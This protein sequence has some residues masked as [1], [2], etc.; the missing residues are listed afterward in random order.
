MIFL[1]IYSILALCIRLAWDRSSQI[2]RRPCSITLL[3]LCP[4]RHL[5]KWHLDIATGQASVLLPIAN[6]HFPTTERLP[7][8][9]RRVSPFRGAPLFSEFA[10]WTSWKILAHTTV[11]W[12]MTLFSTTSS[13]RIKAMCKLKLASDSFT[14]KA[15]GASS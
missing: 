15:D 7:P 8:R 1:F 14:S 12:T 9:W 11:F 4:I 5:P 3:P 2:K 13:W 10:F 6:L